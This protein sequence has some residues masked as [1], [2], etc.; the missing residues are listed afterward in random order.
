MVYYERNVSN[1]FQLF[2]Y[3]LSVSC[4]YNILYTICEN[5]ILYTII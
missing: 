2:I 3:F 1:C 4:R 5:N